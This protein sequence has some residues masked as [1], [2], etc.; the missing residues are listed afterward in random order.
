MVYLVDHIVVQRADRRIVRINGRFDITS[1]YQ[2]FRLTPDVPWSSQTDPDM[3]RGQTAWI[4]RINGSA[5]F[6]RESEAT[7]PL[8]SDQLLR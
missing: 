7:R 3:R 1:Q 4:V 8:P 5:N 2:T 6:C